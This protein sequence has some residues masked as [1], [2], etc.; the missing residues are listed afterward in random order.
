M[1]QAERNISALARTEQRDG[2]HPG[3]Q[4]RPNGEPPMTHACQLLLSQ[5]E[6]ALPCQRVGGTQESS[7]RSQNLLWCLAH[8]DWTQDVVGLDNVTATCS[9][10]PHSSK[11]PGS[12]T[13][14]EGLQE[15]LGQVLQSLT[16]ENPV[17]SPRIIP[18]FNE[19]TV[20]P[21]QKSSK[22]GEG[23]ADGLQWQR[24]LPSNWLTAP[25]WET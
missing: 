21:E 11:L 13:Q 7:P 6:P 20:I 17:M 4:V 15:P 23:E 12:L 16:G 10:R 2:T 19:E 3:T 18:D 24:S 14:P 22:P 8:R 25:S 9:S 1:G 5:E